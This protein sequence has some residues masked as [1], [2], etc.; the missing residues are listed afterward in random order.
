MVN[1]KLR[2]NFNRRYDNHKALSSVDSFFKDKVYLYKIYKQIENLDIDDKSGIKILDIG[3]A[4]GSFAKLLKEKGFNVYGIDISEKAISRAVEAGIKASQCDV[5]QGIN[6][7]DNFFNIV[8]ASEV[9]EHLYDTDYFLKEISRV[10]KGNGCLFISTP[11]L[12]SLK[13]RIRLLMGKY[14]QHSEYRLTPD[15]SGH[16]RNYTVNTLK[17]QII[18]H[19]WRIIKIT[20]PNF[21]C[22]MTKNIPTFIKLVAIFL[23]ELFYTLGSHIIIT[24]KKND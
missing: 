5:E 14:P 1:Y 22:P 8:I 24:A 18:E 9:I 15:S 6:F 20:S 13:N 23:G 19:N 3:C 16:I 10:I 17:L 21:L 11:N 7:P 12:A 4:D 2:H